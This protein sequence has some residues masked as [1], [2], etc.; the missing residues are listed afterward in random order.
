MYIL[1]ELPADKIYANHSALEEIERLIKVS[2]NK[3]PTDWDKENDGSVTK[4]SFL[5]CRSM[6]NKFEHI[7]ADKCLQKSN[8]IILTET[9][10]EETQTEDKE[11]DLP[12]YKS[13]LNSIGRGRGMASYY[14]QKYNH[15]RNLNFAGFSMSKLESD[16]VDVIG[17]YRS[18]D[19]N[20]SNLIVH[21]ES[22]ITKGK[23][24][25][26]GGDLNIC[27]LAHPKNY[28][29]ESLKEKGFN[30]VVSKAT[31]IEGGLIDHVYL[32]QGENS[33]FSYKVE[34]FPKYYSDH[35]GL[36]LILWEV[37]EE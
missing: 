31:H 18:Q 32:N 24:T 30:Q 33:K 3:N 12:D 25:I 21:L 23:T 2:I 6:K 36:G 11:Y 35:D 19:G 1:E 10:L 7:K 5:N 20:V 13:N 37:E 29:T 14:K 15:V 4:I 22:L 16:I 26:I 9:W 27:A 8:I 17:I 28:I 34:N